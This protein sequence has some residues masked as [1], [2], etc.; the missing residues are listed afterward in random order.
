MTAESENVKK[1]LTALEKSV[2]KKL[3]QQ[4]WKGIGIG[5]GVVLIASGIVIG[6]LYASGHI[7]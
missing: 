5:A 1:S 2:N 6:T 4:L 7:K 3:E